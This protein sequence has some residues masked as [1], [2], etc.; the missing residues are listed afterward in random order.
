MTNT[1]LLKEKLEA[2]GLKKGFICEKLDIS[3]PSLN[4]KIE[5]EAP[6]KAYEIQILSTLLNLTIDEKEAIFFA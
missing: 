5:N 1:E 4:K 3:R 2:S 6:F